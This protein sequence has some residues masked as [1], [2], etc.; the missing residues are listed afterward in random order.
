MPAN[1][2]P[3]KFKQHFFPDNFG[4]EVRISD[5]LLGEAFIFSYSIY[6]FSSIFKKSWVQQTFAKVHIHEQ[7]SI[8]EVFDDVID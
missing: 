5:L 4:I 1:S 6:F 2:A 8:K 3:L 7:E